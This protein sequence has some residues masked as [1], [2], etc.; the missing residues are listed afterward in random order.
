MLSVDE[1]M[2]VYDSLKSPKTPA[3]DEL[4]ASAGKSL[5]DQ[6]KTPLLHSF[7]KF[8]IIP[9][10]KKLVNVTPIFKLGTKDLL[11]HYR[12]IS[13]LPCF[14]K[15][16]ERIMHIS[17]YAKLKKHILLFE[18]GFGFRA[19]YSISYAIAELVDKLLA[20][21]EQKYY[22]L[23]MFIDLS[24]ALD[25]V[26]HTI[27]LKKLYLFSLENQKLKWFQ[28]YISHC[29]QFTEYGNFKIELFEVKE[30]I[31]SSLLSLA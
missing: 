20:L 21:F 8:R 30:S 6:T 3:I 5:Y 29:K 28:S 22:V 31:L 1:F 26:N 9:R 13:V 18:R 19:W 24:E 17:F 15:I 4:Y 10:K 25:T 11:T 12:L 7:N 14:S 2:K 27:L 16:L 23:G